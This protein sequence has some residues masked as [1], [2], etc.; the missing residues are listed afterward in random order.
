MQNMYLSVCLQ[1]I[2]MLWR[3]DT[4]TKKTEYTHTLDKNDY[5]LLHCQIQQQ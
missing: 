5:C 1:V 4:Y 3:L 2:I